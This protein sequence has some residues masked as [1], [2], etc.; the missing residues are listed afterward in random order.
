[1]HV[2]M[3]FSSVEFLAGQLWVHIQQGPLVPSRG[4]QRLPHTFR[5]LLLRIYMSLTLSN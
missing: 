3:L 2:N 4:R 5:L 1:M